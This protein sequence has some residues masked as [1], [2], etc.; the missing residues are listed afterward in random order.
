MILHVKW[1]LTQVYYQLSPNDTNI[2]LFSKLVSHL[3]P[4]TPCQKNV[5]TKPQDRRV[6]VVQDMSE[7]T[8]MCVWEA[9]KSAIHV[10]V[11][12]LFQLFHD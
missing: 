1:I 6:D 4:A 5:M 2:F 3:T 7:T 8:I 11:W 9:V 10:L 12:S